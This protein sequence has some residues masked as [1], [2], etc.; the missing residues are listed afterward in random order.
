MSI[1]KN[2]YGD[3]FSMLTP[4]LCTLFK[5]YHRLLALKKTTY[6]PEQNIGQKIN[7]SSKTGQDQQI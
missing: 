2:V 3:S 5:E 1:S 6:N 7:E 4:H